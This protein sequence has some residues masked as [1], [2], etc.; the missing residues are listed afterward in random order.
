LVER[1]FLEDLTGWIF[2]CTFCANSERNCVWSLIGQSTVRHF[3]MSLIGREA[4]FGGVRGESYQRLGL[5]KIKPDMFGALL[6][7]P[8]WVGAKVRARSTHQTRRRRRT[9]TTMMTR[10]R[11]AGTS[12]YCPPR[13][14]THSLPVYSPP[15]PPHGVPVLATSSTA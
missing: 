7:G 15:H 14:P 6:G 8:Y 10:T 13:H 4:V 12:K 11:T 3:I 9:T 2:F 1:V 5:S